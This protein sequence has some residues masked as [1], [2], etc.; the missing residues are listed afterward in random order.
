MGGNVVNEGWRKPHSYQKRYKRCRSKCCCARQQKWRKNQQQR[1]QQQ[2]RHRYGRGRSY[3]RTDPRA[4]LRPVNVNGKRAP[5]MRAPRNTTQF[6]MHEKY[7]ELKKQAADCP[8]YWEEEGDSML[9]YLSYFEHSRG[10]FEQANA[11]SLRN[12]MGPPERHKKPVY[13][14]L[15]P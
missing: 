9:D 7:Q 2:Q 1:Y 15:L 3:Y 8:N 10:G 4:L 11:A 14:W 12:A 5:G 13:R 6:L